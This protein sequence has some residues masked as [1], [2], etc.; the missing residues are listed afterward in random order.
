MIREIKILYHSDFMHM[1]ILQNMMKEY[2]KVVKFYVQERP[3]GANGG[4][5]FLAGQ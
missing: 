1:D 3:R 2:N 4:R 5:C